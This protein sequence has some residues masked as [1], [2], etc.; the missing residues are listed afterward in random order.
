MTVIGEKLWIEMPGEVA[1]PHRVLPIGKPCLAE[2]AGR[3]QRAIEVREIGTPGSIM[4]PLAELTDAAPLSPADLAE[5]DRLDAELAGTIG[6]RKK[7]LPF[8]A[9]LWRRDLFGELPA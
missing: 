8:M 1:R 7:L 6:D 4:I 5:Y 9:L 2:V 3:R